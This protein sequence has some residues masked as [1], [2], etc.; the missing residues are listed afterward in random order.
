MKILICYSKD[1]IK[2][3]SSPI[4]DIGADEALIKTIF[5]GLCGSDIVKISYS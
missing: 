2:I 1:D 4:P 5:C 3:G